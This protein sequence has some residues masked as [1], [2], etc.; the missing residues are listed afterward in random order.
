M[1]M[2]FQIGRSRQGTAGTGMARQCGAGQGRWGMDRR[3]WVR[4]V[5]AWQAKGFE[6]LQFSF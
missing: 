4:Y 3:G 2:D 1:A 5:L 6:R